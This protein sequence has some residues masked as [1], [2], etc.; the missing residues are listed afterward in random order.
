M[1]TIYPVIMSG[2][3]GTR[4]W[5]VSRQS[6]PKQYHAMV[7]ERSM[8]EDTVLRLQASGQKN[9]VAP[10][11]ICADG[12]Q[13]LIDQQCKKIGIPAPT[14]IIEPM[15]RNTAAVAAIAAHHVKNIDEDG[16][17]LLLPADHHIEDNK[18]FWDAV[19][20][21]VE[22]AANGYLTTFGLKPTEPETG[23]GY[24]RRGEALG[25]KVYKID[26][27]VEKP[28]RKTA[29]SY[30]TSGDY[31]WNA[32]IFLFRAETLRKEFECHA[33]D[34]LAQSTM[35]LEKGKMQSNRIFLN[36]EAFGAC[37]AESL[38]YAIME[39]TDFAAIIAPVEIGWNDLGAWSAVSDL[40]KTMQGTSSISLGDVI[41]LDTKDSMVRTDGPLIA[42]I[43]VDNLIIIATKDAV[44]VAHKDKSQ[45]VRR[46][47]DIL[48]KNNR[49]DLL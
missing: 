32:G 29:E 30:L 35:A 25:E 26:Q 27:F 6:A 39:K 22:I 9:I 2:G 7:T 49:S 15:P 37:R 41:A 3:A 5:P 46:I 4:L 42:T 20:N 13:D 38:D 24:I 31:F 19:E 48:K 1:A 47:V 43:G 40:L 36:A 11:V 33:S 16:L 10:I 45:D 44:L 8:F 18:A 12:H 21:G 23:F 17:I 34:I 28:N 14:I